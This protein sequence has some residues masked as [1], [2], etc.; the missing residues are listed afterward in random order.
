MTTSSDNNSSAGTGDK[1][2]MPVGKTAESAGATSAQQPG[3]TAAGQSASA[4]PAASAPSAAPAASAGPTAQAARPATAARAAEPSRPGPVRRFIG[5]VVSHVAFAG[6]VTLGVLGYVFH[7]QI[8]RDVGDRVCA[9]NMLGQYMSVMPANLRS[10]NTASGVAGGVASVPEARQTAN[11]AA[12]ESVVPNAAETAA[13]ATPHGAV[14]TK[15]SAQAAKIADAQE[16]PTEKPSVETTSAGNVSPDRVAVSEA[17]KAAAPAEQ[18]S[19]VATANQTAGATQSAVPVVTS[20]PTPEPVA[21]T[22]VAVVAISPATET[23]PAPGSG[24]SLAKAWQ[25]ARE[26]YVA[27]K[28]EAVAAYREL[29]ATYPE[30][31]EITGEL[32]NIYYAEKRYPE[33]GEQYLETAR[34]LLKQNRAAEASCMADVLSQIAPDKAQQ[35][36]VMTSAPCPRQR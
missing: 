36:R 35:L 27:R 32:G 1:G 25:A 30:M 16:R 5:S 19:A 7:A 34:R 9:E 28:P 11:A 18:N 31:P 10:D 2:T 22:A 3:A 29:A 6:I 15:P 17:P 24:L 13:P 12:P 33:A 23:T 14:E 4:A 8:L 20:E 21:S 26:A